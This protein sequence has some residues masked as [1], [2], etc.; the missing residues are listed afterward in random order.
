MVC[1]ATAICG[2]AVDA[3]SLSEDSRIYCVKSTSFWSNSALLAAIYFLIRRSSFK[4]V[5]NGS[6]DLESSATGSPLLPRGHAL[7]SDVSPDADPVSGMVYL[8]WVVS[9]DSAYKWSRKQS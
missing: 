9:L 6:A 3:V 7:P 5:A 4:I 2:L 8:L 1:C